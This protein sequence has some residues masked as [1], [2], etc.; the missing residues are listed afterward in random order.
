MHICSKLAQRT[1]LGTLQRS[2]GHQCTWKASVVC[3][4][5]LT[6]GPPRR[7]AAP[8]TSALAHSRYRCRSSRPSDSHA[9]VR[10]L[11]TPKASVQRYLQ[12]AVRQYQRPWTANGAGGGKVA[13]NPSVYYAPPLVFGV[14]P[15]PPGCTS[16]AT[17]PADAI[18]RVG[19]GSAGSQAT[20]RRREVAEGRGQGSHMCTSGR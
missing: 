12:G 16:L 4:A 14:R 19:D 18:H 6:C 5:A 1:G 17:G 3:S 2:C 7:T 11:Q 9:S 8:P 13:P 15:R 10:K 20:R